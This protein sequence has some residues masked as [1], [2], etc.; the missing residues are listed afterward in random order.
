MLARVKEVIGDGTTNK[1]GAPHKFEDEV[2]FRLKKVDNSQAIDVWDTGVFFD[3]NIDG[4]TP[5]FERYPF[6][7]G[8]VEELDEAA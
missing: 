2:V 7:D 4:F 3:H 6:A 8:D 5:A 1:A